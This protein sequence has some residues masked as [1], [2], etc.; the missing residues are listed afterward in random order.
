[1]R[2]LALE[3]LKI[4]GQGLARRAAC[5]AHG[6]DEAVFLDPLIEFA[7]AN[8][9]PAERKLALYHGEWGGRSTRCSASSRTEWVPTVA[10]GY[11][12]RNCDTS[13]SPNGISRSSVGRNS[14]NGTSRR[15]RPT[16]TQVP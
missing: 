9:T 14:L 2:D 15:S 6:R 16:K 5:N 11:F 1:M 13:K 12:Q 10:G 3:A 4:A 8:E 7:M